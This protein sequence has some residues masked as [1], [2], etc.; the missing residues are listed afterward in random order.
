MKR[1]L[2]LM[3]VLTLILGVSVSADTISVKSKDLSGYEQIKSDDVLFQ[4]VSELYIDGKLESKTTEDYKGNYYAKEIS[5]KT[6]SGTDASPMGEITYKDFKCYSDEI[7][8]AKALKCGTAGVGVSTTTYFCQWIETWEV[9]Q[10]GNKITLV[11]RDA[12]TILE[13]NN[14][15]SCIP[16]FTVTRTQ[17]GYT[18]T[19]AT[20]AGYVEITGGGGTTSYTHNSYPMY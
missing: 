14:E 19:K 9:D 17:W 6:V 2:A 12:P 5:S 20:A 15:Y 10:F 3:L 16:G 4:V 7:E 8:D 11:E 1:F 13:A 18:S